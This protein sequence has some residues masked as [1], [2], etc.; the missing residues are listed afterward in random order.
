MTALTATVEAG[1]MTSEVEIGSE[2]EWLSIRGTNAFLPSFYKITVRREREGVGFMLDLH[3]DGDKVSIRMF[4]VYQIAGRKGV[5]P[6]EIRQ[7]NTQYWL[8]H[9]SRVAR[10]RGAV[11]GDRLD[12]VAR[13]YAF[14]D[15]IGG[16][17][18]QAVM[19]EFGLTRSTASRWIK[20]A[21]ARSA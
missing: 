13:T 4:A 2:A 12:S 11:D 5:T 19:D 15:A 6:T 20:Q 1:D 3:F 21:L 8:A 16:H 7:V 17:P 9:A 18:R 14:H 10:K